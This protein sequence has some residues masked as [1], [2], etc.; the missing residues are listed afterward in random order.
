MSL[1]IT[2]CN[3]T[4]TPHVFSKIES[5]TSKRKN[6][7]TKIDFENEKSKLISEIANGQKFFFWNMNYSN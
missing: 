6:N 5:E 3:L 7:V 1:F 4:P 2:C